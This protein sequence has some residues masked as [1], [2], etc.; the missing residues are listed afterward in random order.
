[1]NIVYLLLK[2]QH[3]LECGDLASVFESTELSKDGFVNLLWKYLVKS[4]SNM[5]NSLSN[6]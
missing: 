6:L 1:M 4:F 5:S 3:P 2:N